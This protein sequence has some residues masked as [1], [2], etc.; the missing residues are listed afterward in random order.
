M[1]RLALYS[2]SVFPRVYE[3]IVVTY[4]SLFR[5]PV[6]PSLLNHGTGF[7]F[8]LW[9]VSAKPFITTKTVVYLNK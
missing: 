7:H 3:H 5:T 6:G 4:D 9:G 8:A 1:P 2:S